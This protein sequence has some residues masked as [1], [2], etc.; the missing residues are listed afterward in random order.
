MRRVAWK[1]V[2]EAMERV[3]TLSA[4]TERDMSA[5]ERILLA[6][7]DPRTAFVMALDLQFGGIDTVCSVL[8]SYV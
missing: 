5:V 6:D 1:H 8:S 2:E 3:K 7:P 4:N